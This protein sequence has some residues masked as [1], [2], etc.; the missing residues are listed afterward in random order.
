M[1]LKHEQELASIEE[2][3]LAKDERD[4]ERREERAALEAELRE[5]TKEQQALY[6]EEDREVL[7]SKLDTENEA[8]K[9]AADAELDRKIKE[10]NKFKQDEIKFG[11]EVATLKKF[12]A[13]QEL[14]VFKSSTSQLVQLTNSKNSTL[15]GIG[16]A[17]ARTNAAIATAE[18]AI[19]AYASLS[20][21]PIVG[22]VLGAA[23]AAALVAYGVE[24]QSQISA[25]QTGGF[26]PNGLGGA[27]DRIPTMLE[28]NELVVPA[29]VAPNFI[30][31]AG[32]PD[33]P[34]S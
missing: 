19:K 23:A 7:Q 34:G 13:S 32:I 2:F 17:A 8:R 16:K 18:G 10:R 14:Q 21:I 11:T 26:V 1:A 6:N 29:A 22:P 30:Q 20:G 9:K 31:A 28:P 27:R 5:L 15:K 4:A 12:F 33:P 3:E 25:M 24:Q